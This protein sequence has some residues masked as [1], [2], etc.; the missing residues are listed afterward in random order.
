MILALHKVAYLSFKYL[1]KKKAG[2]G[3]SKVDH[4][5]FLI[6]LSPVRDT[7]SPPFHGEHGLGR[8]DC[9]IIVDRTLFC[10]VMSF[11]HGIHVVIHVKRMCQ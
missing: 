7:V 10:L 1:L 8:K 5:D 11:K 9:R 2:R 3:D 4:N 6:R